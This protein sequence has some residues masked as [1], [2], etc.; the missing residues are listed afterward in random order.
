M[1]RPATDL[2][3]RLLCC[4]RVYDVG[5][6]TALLEINEKEFVVDGCTAVTLG[7]FD[8]LHLGHRALI[9][10]VKACAAKNNV[11]SAVFSFTPHPVAF[12]RDADFK[13]ILA[14]NEKAKLLADLGADIYV[15]YPFDGGTA[16]LSPRDFFENTIVK[17]LNCKFLFVGEEFF[18]GKERAGSAEMLRRIGA[19]YGVEVTVVPVKTQGGEKIGSSLVRQFITENRFADAERLLGQPYFISGTVVSGRRLG[20]KLGFP[21]VNLSPP[22]GKL[23]PQN[24]VYV[25]K[26]AVGTMV[27]GSITNIGNNPT[28]SGGFAPKTVETHIFNFNRS[29]YGEN[30]CVYFYKR[31]RDEMKFG[32]IEQLKDQIAEDIKKAGE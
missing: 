28:V 21:T 4:V 6:M 27:Y 32:S 1:K 26:T 24:G 18:F 15:N 2:L 8:G 3:N 17:Q 22:D 12:L 11:K 13:T 14:P 25:T 7:N 31:L 30:V 10:D 29:I 20:G 9:N 16:S 5:G 23:L 19:E